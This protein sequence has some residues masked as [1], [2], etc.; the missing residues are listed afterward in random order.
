MPLT[1]DVFITISVT[2]QHGKES[3]KSAIHYGICHIIDF[4]YT[5]ADTLVTACTVPLNEIISVLV[6]TKLEVYASVSL[7]N[8]QEIT[9]LHSN[10]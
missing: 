2:M 10:Q 4:R 7:E 5:S 8:N 1:N 9:F 3:T 6:L